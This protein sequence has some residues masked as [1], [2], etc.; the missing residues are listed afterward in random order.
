LRK[1]V[2]LDR[3]GVINKDPGG[4]VPSSYVTNVDEFIFLPGSVEAIKKLCNSGYE[5]IVVSN[6]A[7]LSKGHYTKKTL[8]KITAKMIGELK[9]YGGTLKKVYYCIHQNSDNCACRKPKTGLFEM[10]KKELDTEIAGSY[11]IGDGKRDIEAGKKVG[12]KTILLLSGKTK[13]KDIDEWEIKPDFVFKNLLAA[14][15]FI[16]KGDKS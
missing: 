16:L 10:A 3:D 6:Q 13:A 7:G 14:V 9:K 15:N 11:I 4:W 2:F 12:L 8:D 5:I 1:L